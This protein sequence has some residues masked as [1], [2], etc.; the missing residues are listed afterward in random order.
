ME[1]VGRYITNGSIPSMA[2]GIEVVR[3]FGKN[4]V[5]GHVG[6]DPDW[7]SAAS[8]LYLWLTILQVGRSIADTFTCGH[9]GVAHRCHPAS[10]ESMMLN[11]SGRK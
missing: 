8:P 6:I 1:A 3:F 2:D 10:A 5:L 11:P 9:D 4:R 7:I